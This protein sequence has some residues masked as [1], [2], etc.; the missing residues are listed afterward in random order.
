MK[1][2]VW[3]ENAE[4]LEKLLFKVSAEFSKF[5]K[6]RF[7]ALPLMTKIWI[8]T[9]MKRYEDII[10]GHFPPLKKLPN[11]FSPTAELTIQIA[12]NLF[13]AGAVEIGPTNQRVEIIKLFRKINSI[14]PFSD[15]ER[16]LRE[17]FISSEIAGGILDLNWKLMIRPIKKDLTELRNSVKN[18][19][20]HD[21]LLQIWRLIIAHE[22]LEFF[23]RNM[24]K[25]FKINGPSFDLALNFQY[26]SSNYS[27]A[28]L[29]FL[30]YSSTSYFARLKLEDKVIDTE[31]P[32]LIIKNIFKYSSRLEAENT[33]IKPFKYRNYHCPQSL[34]SKYFFDE[35]LKMKEDPFFVKPNKKIIEQLAI[36]AK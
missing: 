36:Q 7:S 19:Q 15:P 18:P 25:V 31:V 34:I 13:Y 27:L 4:K 20:N 9:I 10:P 17:S 35:I 21:A 23:L 16:A 8:C 24:E 2:I 6:E 28:Q 3:I 1:E 12:Q 11:T 14:R 26:L 5:R 22:A 30:I 32:D 29:Y 33:E